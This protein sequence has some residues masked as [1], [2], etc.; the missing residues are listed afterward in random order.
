MSVQETLP[1]EGA[2]PCQFVV[3]AEDSVAHES[4]MEICSGMLARFDAELAFAFSF[5]KFKDLTEP[6]SAH[7]AAEAVARADV[8]LVSLQGHD[9][10]PETMHWLESCAQPRTKAEGAFALVVA[11]TSGVSPA[12]EPLL[13]RLQ[14]VAHRL[15]MDFLPL[16][17]LPAGMSLGTS[18]NAS[19][20]LLNRSDE[21]TGSNH[22]GLNE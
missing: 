20:A 4:A 6:V 14:F 7:W 18:M 9:L 15:R 10:T 2:D 17:P 22:W 1:L 16:V 13:Y 21:A 3:L 8:I 11:R 19:S 12:L 5:W